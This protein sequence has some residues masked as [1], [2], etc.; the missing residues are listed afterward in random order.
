MLR[1]RHVGKGLVDRN[2][3]HR[4]G[5]V[6]QHVDGGVTQPLI[7]PKMAGNEGKIRTKIAGAA[8]RHAAANPECLGLVGCGK[9]D[10]A[11]DGHRLAAQARIEQLFD[12]GVKRVK[13]GMKDG[14]VPRHGGGANSPTLLQA[15]A[16][17][18]AETS[19]MRT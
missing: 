11:P 17:R 7:L 14:G 13:I 12:R 4:R 2:A 1:A 8:T 3:L 15:R 9:N 10:P 18:D 19:N 16:L 5:E 6:A